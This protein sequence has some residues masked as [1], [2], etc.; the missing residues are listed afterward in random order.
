MIWCSYIPIM[1]TEI[2]K[3]GK[4]FWVISYLQVKYGLTFLF[5]LMRNYSAF[6]IRRSGWENF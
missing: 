4:Y 3:I 1:G 2:P 6:F 5:L